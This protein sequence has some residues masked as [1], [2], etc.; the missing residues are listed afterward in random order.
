MKMNKCFR[1]LIALTIF[2]GCAATQLAA[3]HE[4]KA[5]AAD[6]ASLSRQTQLSNER[7]NSLALVKGY[8]VIR[9]WQPASGKLVLWPLFFSMDP[10]VYADADAAALQ[11]SQQA[12][13][14][15]LLKRCVPQQAPHTLLV[16]PT[17]PS[18]AGGVGTKVR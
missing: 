2:S 7:V 14:D 12:L 17:N 9:F 10:E 15:L 4:I 6:C 16:H 13:G 1:S 5:I 8:N 18:G 11:R 3:A